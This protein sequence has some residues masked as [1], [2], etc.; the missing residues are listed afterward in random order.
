MTNTPASPSNA[1]REKYAHLQTD[2]SRAEC[3]RTATQSGCT[4]QASSG[5]DS[6]NSGP[7][8]GGAPLHLPGS[9][10][11]SPQCIRTA[12][13]NVNKHSALDSN[14]SGTGKFDSAISDSTPTPTPT[15]ASVQTGQF[16]LLA[17]LF[18][19][20]LCPQPK[21]SQSTLATITH[22][23]TITLNRFCFDLFPLFIFY[24]KFS[25]TIVT[26]AIVIATIFMYIF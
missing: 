22:E 10:S 2:A 26:Q 5:S 8:S 17:A 21:S 23:Y 9:Q 7:P 13:Q 16:D 19:P 4:V 6:A 18:A 20:S 15:P 11:P 12:E 14:N 25:H 1:Q 24:Y 3:T